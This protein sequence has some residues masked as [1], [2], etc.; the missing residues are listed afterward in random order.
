AQGMDSD[1]AD[2][3]RPG[4]V[5]YTSGVSTCA[6]ADLPV[7]A[8][9]QLFIVCQQ[10]DVK[11][12]CTR[13]DMRQRGLTP[14]PDDPLFRFNCVNKTCESVLSVGESACLLAELGGV[15][16]KAR[17]DG[18]CEVVP[19]VQRNA[20]TAGAQATNEATTEGNSTNGASAGMGQDW[21]EPREPAF[22]QPVGGVDSRLDC[23]FGYPS[24]SSFGMSARCDEGRFRVVATITLGRDLVSR[25]TAM[26]CVWDGECRGSAE[27][28]ANTADGL[29]NGRFDC[30][31]DSAGARVAPWA[32]SWLVCLLICWFLG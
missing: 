14:L 3:E 23:V 1:R 27:Q 2:M 8:R 18:V 26:V 31:S 32:A 12:N 24:G 10:L 4:D 11:K 21:V 13:K 20:T 29:F 25:G 9:A 28:M 16:Q 17:D 5:F 30:F 19:L 15:V 6:A 22:L 7:T